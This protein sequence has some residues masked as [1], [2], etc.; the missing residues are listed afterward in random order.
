MI[1]LGGKNAHWFIASTAVSEDLNNIN[2]ESVLVG[3]HNLK[4]HQM[5]NIVYLNHYRA[6]IIEYMQQLY[7]CNPS[8]VTNGDNKNRS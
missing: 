3:S 8:R 7:S 4:A 6:C 1:T 5:L 2:L